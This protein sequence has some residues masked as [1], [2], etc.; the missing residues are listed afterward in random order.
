MTE[1][2][3]SM[4]VQGSAPPP[5]AN[6]PV[7]AYAPGSPERAGI[8]AK[9]AEMAGQRVDMPLVIGG[10]EVRTGRL[11]TA[12]SPHDPRKVLGEAH[13]AGHAE[14]EAAIGAAAAASR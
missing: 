4:S 10:K 6:E 11:E 13:L 3:S 1:S 14:I 7:Q 8:K 9:L 5:A 2:R 12:E